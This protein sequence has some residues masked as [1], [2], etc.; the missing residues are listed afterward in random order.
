MPAELRV[1]GAPEAQRTARQSG[2]CRIPPTAPGVL[3]TE[4]KGSR[5]KR[6]SESKFKT[7]DF[8]VG[9]KRPT[10]RIKA[11]GLWAEMKQRTAGARHSHT[12]GWQQRAAA[13]IFNGVATQRRPPMIGHQCRKDIPWRGR[14]Q[15]G[16]ARGRQI[17][18]TQQQGAAK[19]IC[20]T[21][22]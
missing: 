20:G 3:K 15:E 8:S 21:E 6:V 2:R 4:A 17:A 13:L 7:L 18:P 1:S 9:R 22:H 14:T 12:S 10:S 5:R 16:G 19:V 11:Q